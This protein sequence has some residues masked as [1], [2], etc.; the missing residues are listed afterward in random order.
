[1]QEINRFIW[2]TIGKS[3]L[4][5]FVAG[6]FLIGLFA[7]CFPKPMM[8]LFDDMGNKEMTAVYAVRVYNQNKTNENLVTAV[9]KN[10]QAG[11][12]KYVIKYG[13][14]LLSLSEDT[15]D[16]LLNDVDRFIIEFGVADA[17]T[18]R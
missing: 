13:D 18:R 17:K 16:M 12:D 7:V 6:S 10:L 8:N 14:K 1:M 5:V 3:V 15:L 2:V 9:V 11:N 4:W